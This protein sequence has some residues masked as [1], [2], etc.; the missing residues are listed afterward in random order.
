MTRLAVLSDVHG[1]LPALEAVLADIEDRGAPDAYWVLGDLA[2]FCPWPSAAIARLRA[3]PNV[4]FLRGNTDRYLATGRR[5][6]MPPACSAEEWAG[7]PAQLAGRDANFRWTV[8]QLSFTDYR[9][10]RDMRNRLRMEVAGYGSITAVHATPASD[11]TNFYPD[12]PDDEIRPYLVGLD[13][14]L[15][16]Y[17]HTHRPVDRS[18]DDIRLVN[19]GSVGLPLDGDPR[20]AYVLLDFEGRKCTATTHR[21]TY[22][23]EA[24]IAELERVDHPAKE[25]VGGILREARA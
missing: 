5:P 12:T 6:T 2:A 16:L 24:V 10:L 22:D 9:F 1:N 25:W 7:M 14:R 4:A 19:G 11:E 21:V 18:V 15:M 23:R 20:P 13:A 8:E 3:L 17:G